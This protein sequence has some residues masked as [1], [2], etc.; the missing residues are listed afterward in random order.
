MK[1][2]ALGIDR[3]DDLSCGRAVIACPPDQLPGC[4]VAA[5]ERFTYQKRLRAC[6]ILHSEVSPNL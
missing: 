1:L 5:K 6:L 3:K 4:L 2:H